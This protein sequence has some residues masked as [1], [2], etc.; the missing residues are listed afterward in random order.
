MACKK[1]SFQQFVQERS[2]C[3]EHSVSRNRYAAIFVRIIWHGIIERERGRELPLKSIAETL[4]KLAR[5][6]HYSGQ[7]LYYGV[8]QYCSDRVS[9]CVQ[10][11]VFALSVYSCQAVINVKS[12]KNDV[13]VT[14]R[15]STEFED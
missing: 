12:N 11:D 7:Y 13:N 6:V 15:D 9:T 3:F 4:R 1:E 10:S 14:T 8:T 2:C 5:D